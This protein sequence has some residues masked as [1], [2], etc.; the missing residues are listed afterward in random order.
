MPLIII[1]TSHIAK[2]SIKDI[3]QAFKDYEPDIVAVEL[4][5]RRL[6]SLLSDTRQHA[7]FRDMFKIGVK[8]YLFLLLGA[9]AEKKLGD[10]VGIKPGADMKSAI[11]KA[12]EAEIPIA[13]IDQDITITLKKLS[14]GISWK[15]KW[16]FLVDL[17]KGVVLG[18]REVEF[19]LTT[20]PD[21]K[22]IA[23]MIDKVKDRYP[24]IYR[25]LV[26]ERNTIMGRRLKNIVKHH[27]E[28]SIL[29]VVG[30]G[31]REEL[32]RLT[33]LGEDITFTFSIN[34]KPTK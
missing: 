7:K 4:D 17:F 19:D 18:K 15:E 8:G 31:H 13:F 6:P 16:H 5:K 10:A 23:K 29:A 25:I 3:H 33:D 11:L 26:T 1:G 9:W 32:L 28:K 14:K 27:P 34:P 24:N 21:Q 30:A 20:V 22:V 2:Q 12:K